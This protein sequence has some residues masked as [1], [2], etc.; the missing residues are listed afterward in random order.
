MAG[1][2]ARKMQFDARVDDMKGRLKEAWGDLTD[3]DVDRAEGQWD[4]MIS[5]IRE[6]T[7]ESIESVTDT[8]NS[9]IDGAQDLG[10]SNDD[11]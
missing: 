7:G 10:S 3:D 1:T 11:S 4:Q 2:D 5:T 8:I 6:R 9:L